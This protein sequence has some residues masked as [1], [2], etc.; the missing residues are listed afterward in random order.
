VVVPDA[1]RLDAAF[2]DGPAEAISPKLAL[3]QVGIRAL[4]LGDVRERLP[5]AFDEMG[6]DEI[7]SGMVVDDDRIEF[8]A[9]AIDQ[10]RRQ[11][12]RE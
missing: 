1:V 8:R 7:A 12:L 3:R 4:C 2:G 5:A 6:A 11:A 9:V 10:D